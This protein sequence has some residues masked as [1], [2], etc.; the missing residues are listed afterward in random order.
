MF[1]QLNLSDPSL[2][3]FYYPI[4]L[5]LITILILLQFI[6]FFLKHRKDD[7]QQEGASE[8]NTLLLGCSYSNTFILRKNN[9]KFSYLCGYILTRAGMWSKAP[10]LYT[11]YSTYHGFQVQEI[12]V[13]YVI[14]AVSAFIAGPITGGL[15]DKFGRKLFCQLYNLLVILNIFLRMTGNIPLAY[16]AQ[17]LTGIGGGLINT[18]FESWLVAEAHK[19]FGHYEVEKERF[20]KKLFKTQVILDA[21]MSIV[22]SAICAIVY[23]YL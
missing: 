1:I 5:F 16:V 22:I 15:A 2:T 18:T 8:N 20:L 4:I 11:L 3:S 12:G 13:L 19:D 14:D 21:V 10:Y 6:I 7:F 9:L 23:V 17:I